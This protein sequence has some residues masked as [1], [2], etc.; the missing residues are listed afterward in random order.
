MPPF[1][2]D[3][4]ANGASPSRPGDETVLVAPPRFPQANDSTDR[5][6]DSARRQV[7]LVEGS[8]PH[9]SQETRDVLRNRLRIAAVLFFIGFFAFLLRWPILLGGVGPARVIAGCCIRMSA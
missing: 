2:P 3:H 9:L 6:N 4:R 8:A 7:A 1:E 5:G